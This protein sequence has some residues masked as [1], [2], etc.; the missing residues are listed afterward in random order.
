MAIMKRR[1]NVRSFYIFT[2]PQFLTA[3]SSK[4]RVNKVAL[5]PSPTAVCNLEV[6]KASPPQGLMVTSSKLL[7]IYNIYLW[8]VCYEFQKSV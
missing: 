3:A 7:S 6:V 5:S 2:H 8:E 4:V 1:I